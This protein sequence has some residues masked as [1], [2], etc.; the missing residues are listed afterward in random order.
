MLSRLD[1]AES[2]IS[3]MSAF[4]TT[5][6]V[7]LPALGRAIR[8]DISFASQWFAMSMFTALTIV[9][10]GLVARSRGRL[11]LPDPGRLYDTSLHLTT[12]EFQRDSL[13]FAGE[14]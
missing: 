9:A 4:V 6:T 14:H 7:A 13:Y 5:L 8:P 2:R 10:L 3:A 11:L 12:W 1:A